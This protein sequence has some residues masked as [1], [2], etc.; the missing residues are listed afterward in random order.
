MA[1]VSTAPTLLTGLIHTEDGN[2]AE[3]IK[4]KCQT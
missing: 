4:Q 1:Y 3:I 2:V